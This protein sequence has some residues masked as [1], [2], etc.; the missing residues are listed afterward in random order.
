[1]AI[2]AVF[3]GRYVKRL[4]LKTQRATGDMVAFAEERLAAIRTVHAFN[5]PSKEAKM[6]DGR[7]DTI[8][9]LLKKEAVASASFFSAMQLSGYFTG[10]ALLGFGMSA[11]LCKHTCI[12]TEV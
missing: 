7:V 3:Y 6:F 9:D 10:V 4:S 12:L 5:G 2:G 8:F 11:S 1:M